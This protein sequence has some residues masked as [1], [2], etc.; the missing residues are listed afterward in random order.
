MR[1]WRGFEARANR[2]YSTREL[3]GDTLQLSLDLL[4]RGPEG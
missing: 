3:A 1:A 2:W 4:F